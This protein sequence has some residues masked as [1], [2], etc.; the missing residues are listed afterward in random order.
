MAESEPK[1]QNVE[2]SES[3]IEQGLCTDKEATDA[4]LGTVKRGLKSRH[5]QFIAVRL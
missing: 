1:K 3:A 4:D 2:I 5:I